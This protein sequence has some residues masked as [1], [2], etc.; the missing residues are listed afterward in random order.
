M[1]SKY[2]PT[3]M[4]KVD[5]LWDLMRFLGACLNIG[6]PISFYMVCANCYMTISKINRGSYLVA[7]GR[8]K[9]FKTDVIH[10]AA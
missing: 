4:V 7:A 9:L 6:R 2:N 8:L 5:A 3:M 10:I 1:R